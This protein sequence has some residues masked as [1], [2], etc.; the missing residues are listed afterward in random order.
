MKSQVAIV[1]FFH[2]KRRADG[3]EF[4]RRFYLAF[5]RKLKAYNWVVPLARIFHLL[6]SVELKSYVCV[7]LTMSNETIKGSGI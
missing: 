1:E 3:W 5:H 2:A 7:G 4:R 6:I